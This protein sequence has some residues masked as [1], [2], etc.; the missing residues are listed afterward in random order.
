V[1]LIGGP[2]AFLGGVGVLFGAFE[3]PSG[4]LYMPSPLLAETALA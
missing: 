1:G 3:N 2:P 4:P